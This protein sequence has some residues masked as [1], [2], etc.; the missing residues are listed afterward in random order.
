MNVTKLKQSLKQSLK[1]S[2]VWI[3]PTEFTVDGMRLYD[4]IKGIISVLEAIEEDE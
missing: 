4:R 2:E 3:N 1:D